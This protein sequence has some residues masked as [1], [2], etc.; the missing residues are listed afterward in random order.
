M[1]EEFGIFANYLNISG[2]WI[3]NLEDTITVNVNDANG[4]SVPDGTAVAFKTYNT[5]G[6]AVPGSDT[7]EEGLASNTLRSVGTYT[8]AQGFL[9][10]TAETNNGG[11]TTHVACGAKD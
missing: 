8:A 9:T 10:V 5:G 3:A 4:N 6:A 7:T 11:R 1:G 2:L